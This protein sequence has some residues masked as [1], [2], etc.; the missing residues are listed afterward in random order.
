MSALVASI[1]VP[2]KPWFADRSIFEGN[3]TKMEC[4]PDDPMSAPGLVLQNGS[5]GAAVLFFLIWYLSG[6]GEAATGKERPLATNHMGAFLLIPPFY[7]AMGAVIGWRV[8]DCTLGCSS[9]AESAP[10]IS[11]F[12]A[13]IMG[14]GYVLLF[15]MLVLMAYIFFERID[16][17]DNCLLCGSPKSL[18]FMLVWVRGNHVPAWPLQDSL[19]L[20]GYYA[21][22]NHPLIARPPAL[23][24]LLQSYCTTIA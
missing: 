14:E 5:L 19:A 6:L 13:N 23:P 22:I 15:M 17:E 20:R 16:G 10:S 9:W 8:V 3:A 7:L 1:W 12:T 21:R 24:T 2:S 18:R 11:F 4:S